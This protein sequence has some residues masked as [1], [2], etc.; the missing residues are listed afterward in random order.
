MPQS[1]NALAKG[2]RMVIV[3]SHTG[4]E[5]PLDTLTIYANEWEILGSRNVSKSE[6]RDVVALT[7]D[8]RVSPVVVAGYGLEDAEEL[9][10]QVAAREVI[11][12]AVIE[13]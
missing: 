12:R 9:H 5:F 1:L 8:G 11:G 13:P 10:R 2:G 4:R 3:G 6:L 7:A